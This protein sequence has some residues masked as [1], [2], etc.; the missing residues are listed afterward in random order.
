MSQGLFC[1][2]VAEATYTEIAHHMGISEYTI[3]GWGSSQIVLRHLLEPKGWLGP[4][5]LMADEISSVLYGERIWD[6][7]YQADEEAVTGVHP[8]PLQDVSDTDVTNSYAATPHPGIAR[9][10]ATLIH[11]LAMTRKLDI[12]HEAKTVSI[13]EIDGIYPNNSPLQHGEFLLFPDELMVTQAIWAD[14]L[15]KT[16]SSS[17]LRELKIA[18]PHQA[19]RR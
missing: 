5:M 10:N 12:D 4:I 19:P 18:T 14:L 2:S 6:V 11:Q 16:A 1:P 17:V 8:V 13:R 15:S 3:E 7:A 9:S